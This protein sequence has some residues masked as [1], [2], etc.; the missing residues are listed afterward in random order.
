LAAK[1]GCCCRLFPGVGA[2]G[3]AC[4]SG[5]ALAQQQG[6][7]GPPGRGAEKLAKAA[8]ALANGLSVAELVAVTGIRR[9]S[10][11]R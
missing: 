1:P 9:A 11:Q 5:S 4:R 6:P 7:L 8:Q 3:S 10:I 2:G